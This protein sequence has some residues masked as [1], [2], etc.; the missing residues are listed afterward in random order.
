MS[1]LPVSN[2]PVSFDP[3]IRAGEIYV[4]TFS[5]GKQY[6]G[7]TRV[8]ANKRMSYH[9]RSVNKRQD[10]AVYSAWIKYGEPSLTV[11]GEYHGNDLS[12]AERHWISTL[13]TMTPYGY[14]LH[15]GGIGG[16]LTDASKLIL[17]VKA[18]ERW[19]KN[20]ES[21]VAAMNSPLTKVVKSQA[22]KVMWENNEYRKKQLDGMRDK[23][24]NDEVFKA[25]HAKAMSSLAVRSKM[26]TAQKKANATPERHQWYVNKAKRQM[27]D[28]SVRQNLSIKAKERFKDDKYL[29]RMIASVNTVEAKTKKSKSLLE[30]FSKPEEKARRSKLNKTSPAR[31]IMYANHAKRPYTSLIPGVSL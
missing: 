7:L 31:A 13:N 26:S 22:S 23:W 14:N 8:G 11:L 20:R 27:E 10:L 18:K 4:L 19:A 3:Y 28:P 29:E 12:D 2:L 30:A 15:E 17:S 1:A 9:R 5:N 25:L 16:N 21:L 24:K 6:V